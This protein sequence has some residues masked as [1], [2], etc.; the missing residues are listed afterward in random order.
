ME[1]E[2]DNY[3]KNY[4]LNNNQIKSKYDHSYRVMKLNVKYA[5]KLKFNEE[6]IKI[7]KIIGLLHDIGR[8][9]QYKKFKIYNDKNTIDHADYS[10]DILFNQNQIQNFNVPSKYY[11][12]I[13]FAVKNHNK[14]KISQTDDAQKLKHARLIRDTDKIDILNV[15]ASE[16]KNLDT[17]DK[18]SDKVIQSIKKHEIVNRNDCQNPNDQL[19]SYF[20]FVFDINNSVCLKE[21]KQ[22]LKL[23]YEKL[24]NKEI[25]QKIYNIVLDYINE[26]MITC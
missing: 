24:E 17:K 12:V 7:A 15:F 10:V 26:R 25:F 18:I 20:A 16:V 19:A 2:F 23:L 5:K 13:E 1:Q 6:N 21:F 8:F 4:N 22:N 11:K 14:L 3:V 9:E